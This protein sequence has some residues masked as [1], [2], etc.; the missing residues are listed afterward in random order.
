MMGRGPGSG[1]LGENKAND[2]IYKY[3]NV[4][5]ALIADANYS[6][7][8]SQLAAYETLPTQWSTST[9]DLKTAEAKAIG[10]WS[11][12]ASD[13]DGWMGFSN[14]ANW[15]FTPGV[16]PAQ[17]VD[18]FVGVAE[19]ELTEI[20]GRV[21][22]LDSVMDLFRYSAPGQRLGGGS[23][24]YFSIDNGNTN[25]GKWNN[26][27]NN[28]QDL[29]DWAGGPAPQG[30]DAFTDAAFSGV[31]NR[32]S[33]S[34]VTLMN[35]LG[36]DIATSP[37]EIGNGVT[38]WVVGP[39][40][41]M[42]LIV[43]GGGYLEVGSGGTATD[44]TRQR[45]PVADR[46]RGTLPDAIVGAGATMQVT[47]DGAAQNGRCRHRRTAGRSRRLGKRYSLFRRRQ[48]DGFWYGHKCNPQ[49]PG[50]RCLGS[51]RI[52][53]RRSGEFP[54]RR[55]RLADPWRAAWGRRTRRSTAGAYRT[56]VLSG[57]T[58]GTIVNSG[59]IQ[60]GHRISFTTPPSM[61]AGQVYVGWTSD[62]GPAV[63]STF[64]KTVN[65]GE[66]DG[67][68][69]ARRAGTVISV[70][71]RERLFGGMETSARR[72]VAADT[73][74]ST[75]A[76]RRRHCRQQRRH[77]NGFARLRAWPTWSRSRA[78]AR[79]RR[80]IRYRDWTR[81]REWRDAGDR[82]GLSGSGFSLGSSSYLEVDLAAP[83][84]CPAAYR[85]GK[86]RV[87]RVVDNQSL[88]DTL[89]PIAVRPKSPAEPRLPISPNNTTAAWRSAT[90]INGSV[91][92]QQV[93]GVARTT[94]VDPRRQP[95]VEA[96][97]LAVATTVNYGGTQ[98]VMGIARA[99]TVNSS[100]EEIISAG[101]V[102]S[103]TT[104]SG[105]EQDIYAGTAQGT[106]VGD[107]GTQIVHGGA[108]GPE[109]VLSTGAAKAVS[110]GP[111][112]ADGAT[113]SGQDPLQERGLRRFASATT[114]EGGSQQFVGGY[115]GSGGV[116][117]ATTVTQGIEY[118]ASGGQAI[119]ATL[120]GAYAQQDIESGGFAGNTLVLS[121]SQI[122]LPGGVA[123]GTTLSG[124]TQYV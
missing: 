76:N 102:A 103:A 15:S 41:A 63:G 115:F 37:N 12:N 117:S 106:T 74:T 65:G 4:R 59:G 86:R 27:P 68:A 99:T 52:V 35:V 44:A 120:D 5:A 49:W 1:D 57:A 78:A 69:S 95:D 21:A 53:G 6:G 43:L 56:S 33:L 98:T 70:R 26:D 113:V 14:T 20:L 77:D 11:G 82:G 91:M 110:S 42:D 58:V 3:S 46:C 38:G 66:E 81:G 79:R 123:S 62:A 28:G 119:A 124:G 18:Y 36:W 105:G 8:A 111:G 100:G 13:V 64:N 72:S 22:T 109:D 40:L 45:R 73:R 114:V 19:H 116:A 89:P 61:S 55:L 30:D 88:D 60:T 32:L 16:T 29:G 90:T 34:D 107:N 96:G 118:V 85:L 101:G 121:G 92:F 67:S 2:G 80:I 104:L 25:L 122:V 10:V 7:S 94:T 51:D 93:D 75:R 97:G 23:T 17:G 84:A 39:H 50:R 48:R 47:G 83:P 54:D 71:I 108:H 24:N 112:V 31:I 87:G 9:L